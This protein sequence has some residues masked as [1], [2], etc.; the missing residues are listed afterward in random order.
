MRLSPRRSTAVIHV[1]V[2]ERPRDV[3]CLSLV[4]FNSTVPR[5]HC[6]VTSAS[7]LSL[8]T[9][10]FRCLWRNVETSS[11]THFVVVYRHQQTA[12]LTAMSVANFP[13][14][15]GTLLI[16]TDGR[17]IDNPRCS[18]ILVENSDVF[19]TPVSHLLSTLP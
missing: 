14:F 5:A 12:P 18:E 13:R 16:T 19:H 11:H 2:A 9:M 17:S 1:A 10:L 3:S 8:R 4:C 6:L 15:G 7:D